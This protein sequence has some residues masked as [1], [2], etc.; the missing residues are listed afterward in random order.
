MRFRS[1]HTSPSG[2]LFYVF[3]GGFTVGDPFSDLPV[4]GA[5][6]ERCRVEVV[7]PRYRLAPE[8]PAPAAIDDCRAVYR[9]LVD[10][11]D[12]PRLLAGE[13]AGGNLALLLAQGAVAEGLPLPAAV[14]L[15]SP[16]TDLRRDRELF[17]PVVGR[18]PTLG[19]FR[20]DEVAVGL[21]HAHFGDAEHARLLGQAHPQQAL[22]EGQEEKPAAAA[23]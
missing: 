3:G 6:A 16:A 10:R 7:A 14:A 11:G 9:R 23:A 19:M 4:I 20:I 21:G 13:S 15:L 1:S 5:L 17:E 18:D 8:H 12:A 22:P 2:T